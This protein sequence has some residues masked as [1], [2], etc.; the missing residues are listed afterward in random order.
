MPAELTNRQREILNFIRDMIV[1]RGYGPTLREIGERFAINSPN[2]I[3]CHIK[4][5]E[6]KG[7][8]TRERN[9]ARSITLT[10]QAKQGSGIPLVTLE[11]ICPSERAVW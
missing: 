9:L 2:G 7:F 1:D 6:K 8:I 5:L 4:A 3:M 11:A 10:N